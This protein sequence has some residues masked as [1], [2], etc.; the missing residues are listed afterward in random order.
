M[1]SYGNKKNRREIQRLLKK[2]SK[3][4][5]CDHFE[6]HLKRPSE[7][8]TQAQSTKMAYPSFNVYFGRSIGKASNGVVQRFAYGTG[9]GTQTIG[10]DPQT[11]RFNDYLD[12]FDEI[13]KKIPDVDHK[14]FNAVSVKIYYG[15]RNGVNSSRIKTTNRHV[16]VN[17]QGKDQPAKENSQVPGSPVLILT[18][19]GPK[20]LHF[21]LGSSTQNHRQNTEF[22]FL[23]TDS[24]G[25]YLDVADE[26][27][28]EEKDRWM[29]R[30]TMHPKNRKGMVIS[31]MFRQVRNT[32]RVNEVD[33][34]LAEPGPDNAAFASVRKTYQ[35]R[36][37]YK[38]AMEEIDGKAKEL[39]TRKIY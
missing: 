12:T 20:Y 16:D 3:Q 33:G 18:F 23:Q 35:K 36:R 29:H 39:M 2:A 21:C 15:L 24:S 37:D 5:L 38:K 4:V 19:G 34:T 11:L 14:S 9:T 1:L 13:L 25:F 6:D 27:P 7:T 31:F 28:N 10:L 26:N 8:T 17:Y 32:R 30:S 22:Y